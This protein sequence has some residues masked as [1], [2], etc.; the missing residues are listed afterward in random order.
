MTTY[1]QR[2]KRK[3]LAIAK[4]RSKAREKNAHFKMKLRLQSE[5]LMTTRL[6][7]DYIRHV[8]AT[9]CIGWFKLREVKRDY[10]AFRKKAQKSIK[11]AL[12]QNRRSSTIITG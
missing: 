3:A 4:G 12:Y 11:T 8:K 9:K 10:Q 1:E 5:Y 7:R 2:R 6:M